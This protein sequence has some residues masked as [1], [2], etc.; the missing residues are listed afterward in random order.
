M[1][2]FTYANQKK[3]FAGMKA[4]SRD[5]TVETYCAGENIPFGA[6][7]YF[8]KGEVFV[9]DERDESIK[10]VLGIA[11]HS[12][13]VIHEDYPDGYKKGDAV[14]VMTIGAAWVNIH[15]LTLAANKVLPYVD[16]AADS[17]LWFIQDGK[18]SHQSSP[19]DKGTG[20]EYN[21][22]VVDVDEPLALVVL[23]GNIVRVR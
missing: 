11:I 2:I 1:E 18:L 15:P 13:G 19:T 3:A 9:G 22:R 17:S 5:D 8:K 12:H 6:F 20:G 23:N 7:V 4:D 10:N 21:L 16:E 14:S